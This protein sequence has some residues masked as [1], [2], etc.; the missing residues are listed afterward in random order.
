MK[1]K[2]DS[3]NWNEKRKRG[4]PKFWSRLEEM[5]PFS[6]L[7]ILDLGCGNGYLSLDMTVKGAAKVVGLDIMDINGDSISHAKKKL[8][9][10]PGFSNRVEFLCM[11]LKD[12]DP[13]EQFDLVISRDAFEHILH[14]EDLLSEIVKCLKP[15]GRLYVRFGLLWNSPIAG[16]EG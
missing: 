14:L 12:Y 2:D 7:T 16:I 6:A 3:E 15:R 4:I 5:P 10:Y 1:V 13:R 11:D 8:E 9:E